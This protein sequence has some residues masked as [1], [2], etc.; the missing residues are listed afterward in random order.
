MSSPANGSGL[1]ATTAGVING[2]S[3][4]LPIVE[5]ILSVAF[6]GAGTTA[7]VALKIAQ[8][9][10]AGVP[11]A[12]ALYN[13]FQTSTPPTA[14]Q[15]AAYIADENSAYIQLMADIQAKLGA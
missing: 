10:I 4:A 8:G 3:Q 11:E 15:L 7:A 14:E 12:V 13:Q 6:P 2:I 5:T 1:S 9:V